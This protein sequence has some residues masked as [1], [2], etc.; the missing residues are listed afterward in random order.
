MKKEFILLSLDEKIHEYNV[1]LEENEKGEEVF[2]LY[3]SNA[4]HWTNP[5]EFLLSITDTGNGVILP[6][7]PKGKELAY[8]YVEH[9]R[10]LLDMA[11]SQN[12][13][14][15]KFIVVERNESIVI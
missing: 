14:P 12:H 13:H 4:A 11:N 15:S 1:V 9:L 6:N 10:I 2:S 3:N 8:C 7:L 5:N